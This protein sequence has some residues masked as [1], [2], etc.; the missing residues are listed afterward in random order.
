MLHRLLARDSSVRDA[1]VMVADT[2]GNIEIDSRRMLNNEFGCVCTIMKHMTNKFR[3]LTVLVAILL[4][5]TGTNLVTSDRS[6]A[7]VSPRIAISPTAITLSTSENLQ[8]S[9]TLNEPIIC[10]GGILGCLVELN[11]LA[12]IPAG[13]F[14]SPSKIE[15]Q[16]NEWTQPRTFT[17]SITNQN[18]FANNQVVH[19]RALA[20]S[21]SE[22]YTGYSVD[23]P[24]TISIIP[25]TTVAPTTTVSTTTSIVSTTTIAPTTTVSTTSIATMTAVSI[26]IVNQNSEIIPATGT[27]TTT[28]QYAIFIFIAGLALT[29]RRSLRRQ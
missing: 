9:A 6:H 27:N 17:V 7:V 4:G 13:L 8:L 23:I 19:L 18:L 1:S 26:A 15:W 5:I 25:T 21:L 24:V 11:F 29:Y 3:F 16:H 2:G 14:M 12:N 28:L 10:P 22:Y 20:E